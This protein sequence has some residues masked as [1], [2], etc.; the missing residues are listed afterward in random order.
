MQISGN[1]MEGQFVPTIVP[2]VAW[3]SVLSVALALV[4]CD[5]DRAEATRVYAQGMQAFEQGGATEAAG[6]ME[7][8][9]E[10]D[11]TFTTAAYTLGQLQQQRLG[12]PESAEQNFR[13]AL[14]H[15]P[16]NPRFAYRLGTAL[17]DQG[18]HE[19]ALQYLE[20]ALAEEPENA[21]AWFARGM[22]QD[23]LGDA[24]AAVESFMTSIELEPRLRMDMDDPGGEHY[25]ALG[26]LYLRYRLFDLAAQVYENGFDNVTDS[27]R[28]A[29]G[30]GISLMELGRY[31]ESIEAFEAALELDE[32][33]PSANYNYAVVL[34]RAGQT[35]RA[36][37]RLGRLVETGGE[38]GQDGRSEAVQALLSDLRAELEEDDEE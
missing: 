8:A 6:Y 12:D 27:V 36:V 20:Q 28:L 16:D 3:V 21:R 31:D 29:H 15:E 35:E 9:L 24:P 30:L 10:L 7:R 23:A 25:H 33:H 13:R 14:D 32:T 22:S 38:W 26:D 4:G 11:P 1:A 37:E 19:D 5:P 18:R 17:A 2:V 34:D